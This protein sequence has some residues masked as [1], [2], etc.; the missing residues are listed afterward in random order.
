V[1]KIY[2]KVSRKLVAVANKVDNLYC[3]I[4]NAYNFNHSWSIGSNGVFASVTKLTAKEKWH[5]A[6]GNVSF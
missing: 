3:M 2:D 5:R 1:Q 6:L 4:E